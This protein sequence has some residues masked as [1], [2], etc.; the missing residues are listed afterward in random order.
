MGKQKAS[1]N[2]KLNDTKKTN[3]QTKKNRGAREHKTEG[4]KRQKTNLNDKQIQ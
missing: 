3:K 1:F 4:N 2:F